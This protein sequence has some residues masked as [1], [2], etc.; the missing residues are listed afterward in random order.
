V[1]GSERDWFL[2]GK[3]VGTGPFVLESWRV[4]DRIRLRRSPTY[5]GQEEVALESVD[6]LATEQP[7]T[8][9]NLYLSGDVDWL[10]SLYPVDLVDVLQDRPDF[11]SGPGM[12]VYYYR[13]NVRRPPLDDPRV[14]RAIGLAIDRREI[15]NEVL[16]LGQIP[17][18]TLV[19][20]GMPGYETPASG[21]GFDP[22]LARALLAEAGY[23]GGR[24]LRELGLIYNTHDMHKKIAEVIAD[25]L[26]RTLGIRVQAYNQEWQ[27]YLASLRAGEYDIARA[28]WIGD[29]LDPNTFLDIW[30]TGGGNNQTGW[31][32]PAYD[33]LIAAAADVARASR[34]AAPLLAAAPEPERLR[35]RLDALGAAQG[36]SARTAALARVRMELLHQAESILVGRGFPVI[37]I[38][39]YVV[40]G[41]LQP[42]VEGFY[43]ELELPDGSRAANLQDLHPLR[44][45]SVRR[46]TPDAAGG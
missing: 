5:W 40:S 46:R 14:R 18:V 25:Q 29:Y 26:R 12:I 31:G 38:Y 9:L 33:A 28:G 21:L 37:P 35:A 4:N 13:L 32:D 1:E 24:G 6:V 19:P 10:P 2:P 8:A 20:P 15:T 34:S 27:S 39:F 16:G 17:A 30:L 45:L 7:T 3:L 43:S 23:P 42:H 22:E 41:L 44:D 36:A 11:Y